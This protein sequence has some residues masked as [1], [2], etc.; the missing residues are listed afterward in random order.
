[1]N[2]ET[3]LICEYIFNKHECI[4]YL[5]SVNIDP[6]LYKYVY[7]EYDYTFYKEHKRK[8]RKLCNV[9]ESNLSQYSNLMSV[10]YDPRFNSDSCQLPTSIRQIYFDIDYAYYSHMMQLYPK[11][12]GWYAYVKN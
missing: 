8:V 11:K 9:N 12:I 2:Y 4:T 3:T 6:S 7:E 5:N 1:M 10:T